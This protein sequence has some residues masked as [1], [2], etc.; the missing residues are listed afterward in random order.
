M[1][2][3]PEKAVMEPAQDVRGSVLVRKASP[4][5]RQ[6]SNQRRAEENTLVT[7]RVPLANESS[8]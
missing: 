4:A 6:A 7:G 2:L 8:F 1:V 5:L 3:V